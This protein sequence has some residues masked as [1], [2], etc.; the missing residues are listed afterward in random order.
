MAEN[1]TAD[2]SNQSAEQNVSK[3]S[4]PAE[5]SVS[6]NKTV[7]IGCDHGGY[8][9]KV[10]ILKYLF[11]HQFIVVDCGTDSASA[12]VDYPEF[13]QK[14]A[15]KVS[16]GEVEFGILMCS[17]G[18]GIS[19]AANKVPGIRCAL[20]A[21]TFSAHRSREHNDANVVALGAAVTGSGLAVDIVDVFLHTAFS[22]EE[23]HKR[24]IAGIQAVEDTF[25]SKQ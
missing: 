20:V 12:S 18:I 23:R 1:T 11:K 17:T 4:Q 21:D 22:E 5:Q 13:A 14:V 3:N 10:E 8:P 25:I 24:R 15:E 7:A 6:K 19:I 16:S 9:L 2:K